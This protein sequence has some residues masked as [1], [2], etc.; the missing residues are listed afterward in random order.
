[1]TLKEL[2]QL[3]YLDKLIRRDEERLEQ[4]RSRLTNITTNLDGMPK[5]TGVSDKVGNGVTELVELEKK[6]AQ[7]RIR[8]EKEK[9]ELE[10]YLRRIEDKQIRL[11][12][13]LRFVDL[14]SWSEIAE[15]IGGGNTEDSVK[16]TCYRYLKKK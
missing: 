5:Q 3:Y 6:I 4:I 9:A 16:K 1:M 13:L 10:Q 2:S 15:K 8:F 14:K 12:F 11:I 7:D